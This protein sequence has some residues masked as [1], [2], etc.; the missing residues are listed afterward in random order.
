MCVCVDECVYSVV[1]CVCDM[2]MMVMKEGEGVLIVLEPRTLYRHQVSEFMSP[3]D[4]VAS[5]TP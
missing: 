2:M 1:L 4:R 5:Y 3:T